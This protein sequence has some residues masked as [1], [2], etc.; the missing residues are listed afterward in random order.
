MFGLESQKKKKPE[1]FVFDLEKEF[2]DPQKIR[3]LK[4]KLEKRIQQVKEI[5]RD[6]NEKEEFDHY[7]VLLHGYAALVKVMARYILSKKGK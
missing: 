6:G 7:G 1:E 5:L 3:D 4:D 2:A